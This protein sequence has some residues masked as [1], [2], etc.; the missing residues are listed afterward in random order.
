MHLQDDWKKAIEGQ[1]WIINYEADLPSA[2]KG[3]IS[4]QG[5]LFKVWDGQSGAQRQSVENVPEDQVDEA[6]KQLGVANTGW[7]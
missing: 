6:L 1:N 2:Q 5:D 7:C 4:R 3:A